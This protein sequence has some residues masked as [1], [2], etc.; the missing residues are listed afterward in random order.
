[1]ASAKGK[2]G[3]T[4]QTSKVRVILPQSAILSLC[5]AILANRIHGFVDMLV[6]P[7]DFVYVGARPGTQCADIAFA[8]HMV[9]EKALDDSSRNT[10]GQSDIGQF[11]DNLL[12]MSIAEWLAQRGAPSQLLSA[13]VRVICVPESS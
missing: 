1:M 8:C 12:I 6:P 11:Y 7:C 3:K 13:V 9:I 5:D 10:L 2:D 4:P